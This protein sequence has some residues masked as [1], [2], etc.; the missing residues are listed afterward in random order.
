MAEPTSFAG[1]AECKTRSGNGHGPAGLGSSPDTR[2]SG[3]CALGMGQAD[4]TRHSY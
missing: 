3:R 4:G 2:W 1:K